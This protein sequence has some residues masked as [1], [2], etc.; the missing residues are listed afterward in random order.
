MED[1]I[2]GGLMGLAVGDALGATTE[3][4]S[5][6]E[7]IKEHGIVDEMIG[8]GWMNVAPGETTDDTA[9][10]LAVA[11]GILENP[12]QPIEAI[13]KYFKQ[14]AATGPKDIG[15]TTQLVLSK[16]PTTE[17][18][19]LKASKASHDFLKKSAG[20]GSLMRC[21]PVAL[22]YKYSTDVADISIAQSEMTHYDH[23]ASEACDIYNQIA[24]EVLNGADLKEI[25][26]KKI[27]GT[28]YEL[29][30]TRNPNVL[31]DGFVVNTFKWVLR[32]LLTTDTYKDAVLML[33][34]LGEDADTT[35]AIAGGLAGLH[36]GYDAIP[37]EWV[38]QIDKKKEILD[39]S[40]Q[41]FEK[42]AQV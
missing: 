24:F 42:R 25:I 16:K 36:Y 39:I 4:M 15:V 41:L 2:K 35:A 1:K 9:M 26:I 10:T 32:T 7:I 30:E 28:R 27:K 34:N 20:N 17:V 3:F 19:W 22:F 5:E 38:D 40:K 8:G 12:M 11:C 14:W 6:E 31:P 23:L 37:K 33:V 18:E 21:L 29:C 13:G